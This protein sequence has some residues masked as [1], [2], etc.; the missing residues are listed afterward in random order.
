MKAE[1][2]N[3]DALLNKDNT[4]NKII[5]FPDGIPG[6]ENL[7]TFRLLNEPLNPLAFLLQSVDKPD[8]NLPMVLPQTFGINYD[9]ELSDEEMTL[10]EAN[11]SSEIII[12]LVMAKEIPEEKT[13]DEK[14]NSIIANI[15]GPIIINVESM[16]GYQKILTA[17][18]CSLNIQS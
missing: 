12:F 6:F 16:K 18:D 3:T 10:I 11:D 1:K 15:A 8:L 9:I 17:M 7:K 4:M 13:V 14:R 2:P 5:V